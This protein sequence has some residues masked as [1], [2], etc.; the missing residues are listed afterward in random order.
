MSWT[1]LW[2]VYCRTERGQWHHHWI[3]SNHKRSPTPSSVPGTKRRSEW[4]EFYFTSCVT[5]GMTWFP[6]FHCSYIP[7]CISDVLKLKSS[8]A[9]RS[10]CRAP[11][12]NKMRRQS[13]RP[14][15][16][17]TERGTFYPLSR[18]SIVKTN[19]SWHFWAADLWTTWICLIA[20]E[21]RDRQF[22][23]TVSHLRSY[24]QSS[25]NKNCTGDQI[26]WVSLFREVGSIQNT[27]VICVKAYLT[28]LINNS[29]RSVLPACPLSF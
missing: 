9:E 22:K 4:T 15:H 6:P 11:V 20:S 18:S 7:V 10:C 14:S 26:F 17:D 16:L 24:K 25:K 12:L 29:W 5:S 13:L 27:L 19:L 23:T 21:R 1:E 8:G 3:S 2:F 28:V